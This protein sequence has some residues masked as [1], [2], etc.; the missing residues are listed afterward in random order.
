MTAQ[1]FFSS[2]PMPVLEMDVRSV[3]L[4]FNAPVDGI[5]VLVVAAPVGKDPI[6][7]LSP[8]VRTA[9]S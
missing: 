7:S 6:N 5:S 8:P 4:Q 1:F 9:R 3:R 2:A